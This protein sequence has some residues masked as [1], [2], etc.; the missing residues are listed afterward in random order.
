MEENAKRWEKDQNEI[1]NQGKTPRLFKNNSAIPDLTLKR[2]LQFL[3]N[4]L[5]I[6]DYDIEVYSQARAVKR[7]NE[8][9][10]RGYEGEWPTAGVCFCRGRS[11]NNYDRPLVVLGV[12]GTRP[13]RRGG[14]PA[15][16]KP[17]SFASP[18]ELKNVVEA[19]VYVAAHELRH[20]RQVLSLTNRLKPLRRYVPDGKTLILLRN[21]AVQK[22]TSHSAEEYDCQIFAILMLRKWALR[23]SIQG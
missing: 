10:H 11:L 2:V 5:G 3:E 4:E 21:E 7:I 15:R 13:G 12:G 9:S 8:L 23:A 14:F 16:T 1:V 6:S 17:P 18:I 22:F 19:L 20:V